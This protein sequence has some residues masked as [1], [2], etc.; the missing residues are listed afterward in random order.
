M[1]SRQGLNLVV[2][3]VGCVVVTNLPSDIE[4]E[5]LTLYF[6]SSTFCPK[7]GEVLFAQVYSSQHSALVVFRD[8]AG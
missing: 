7:G 4:V 5:G 2:E 1:S 8:P 6:E 3:Q